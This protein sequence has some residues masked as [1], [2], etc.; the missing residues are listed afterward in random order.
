[1]TPLGSVHLIFSLVAIAAGSAV[2]LTPKGTRWHRTLGH[3]YATTILGTCVTAMGL[4]NLT[5]RFG[6][7]HVAAIVGALTLVVGLYTV[8]ARR[9]RKHWIETH[10]TWM[11]WS[12]VGLMSAFAAE[13]LTRFVMPRV[14]PYLE[15]R[16]MWGAFWTTVLVAS[17]AVGG[18]GARLVKTR[19]PEAVRR[20]P[21]AMRRERRLVEEGTAGDVSPRP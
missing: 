2:L 17:F 18:V 21:E 6:P 5:G 20:T 3:V 11:S 8:L 13:S 19:L 12:Y 1:M 4:Y 14:A 9:P 16:A 7:F 10:A 15:R